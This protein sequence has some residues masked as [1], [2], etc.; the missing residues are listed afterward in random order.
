LKNLM[1]L[2]RVSKSLAICEMLAVSAAAD[3]VV[4][5]LVN[6]FCDIDEIEFL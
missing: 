5:S 2:R 3:P 4:Y 1:I 6:S